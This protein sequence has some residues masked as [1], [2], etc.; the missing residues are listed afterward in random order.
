MISKQAKKFFEEKGRE[1]AEVV[2][3]KYGTEHYR[4]M[5]KKRW[6]KQKTYPQPPLDNN[7]RG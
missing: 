3:Q 4:N 1:G 2:R 6:D 7:A 5:A